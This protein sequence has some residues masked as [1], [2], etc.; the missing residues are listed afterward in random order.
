MD[1]STQINIGTMAATR[2]SRLAAQEK[3]LDR[4]IWEAL[5]WRGRIIFMLILLPAL[6]GFSVFIGFTFVALMVK[7]VE[8]L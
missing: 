1:Y 6:I 8:P 2:T 5:S 4:T 3:K 7:V